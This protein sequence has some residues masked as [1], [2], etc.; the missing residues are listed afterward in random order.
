MKIIIYKIFLSLLVAIIIITG[1]LTKTNTDS[2][3]ST[4]F[5]W[6][7]DVHKISSPYGK[8]NLFTVHFHNG[9]DI[10]ARQG[11]N[12]Y[13]ISDGVV[14]FTNFKGS[15]GYTIVLKHDG[16]YKSM[17]CHVDPNFLVIEG[18]FVKQGDIIAK[19][20]PAR[21]P[22]SATKYYI[23]NGYKSNGMT[24]GPHLHFSTIF[25]GKYVN[26]QSLTYK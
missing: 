7:S 9:I 17:Y 23:F 6:P 11:S 10:P 25:K 8:R 24:T 3:K 20:G 1:L 13:A 12:I 18:Q 5:I 4:G 16:E 2:S 19:I 22:N 15:F 21:L 26:P 14:E